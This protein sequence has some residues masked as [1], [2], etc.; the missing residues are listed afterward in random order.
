M[1][2]ASTRATLDV[3]PRCELYSSL[4]RPDRIGAPKNTARTI[5]ARM[6]TGPTNTV[7]TNIAQ[8]STILK[9]IGP[10]WERETTS[11]HQRQEIE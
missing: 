10:T 1:P 11:F 5:I 6:R 7:P 4:R 2:R 9:S 8:K 3:R